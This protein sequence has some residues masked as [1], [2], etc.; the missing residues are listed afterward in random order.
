MG[1]LKEQLL[2]NLTPEEMDERFELSAFEYVEYME[3]YKQQSE[4][5]P[6][7]VVQQLGEEQQRLEQEYYEIE[8]L[9]DSMKLKYTDNDILDVL[10]GMVDPQKMDIIMDKFRDIWATKVGV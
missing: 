9:N 8:I 1:K 6:A 7:D 4:Q 5:I 10:D 3:N 2:N